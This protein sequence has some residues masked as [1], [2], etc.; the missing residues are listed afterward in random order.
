MIQY[1]ELGGANRPLKFSYYGLKAVCKKLKLKLTDLQ[2]IS[3]S[4]ENVGVLTYFAL[5]SG[6]KSEGLSE[7][8]KLANVEDWL[9]AAGISAIAQ[10][11]E[12]FAESQAPKQD[13]AEEVEAE[14]EGK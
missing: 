13:V 2:R 7:D 12:L 3:D 10:V 6:A 9:D 11:L 4:L 8:F 5:K 1:I 14:T